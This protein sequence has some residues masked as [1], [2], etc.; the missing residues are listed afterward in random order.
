MKK[1]HLRMFRQLLAGA[2]VLTI[3][4]PVRAQVSNPSTWSDFVHGSGNPSVC[5]TFRMQ[6][7]NRRAN[8]NWSYTLS[9]GA[10]IPEG[11]KTLIVPVGGGI[12]LS[13]IPTDGYQ[14]VK[15]SFEFGAG[16]VVVGED[17]VVNYLYD[18]TVKAKSV[19]SPQTAD[20]S[21]DKTISF[22]QKFFM[23]DDSPSSLEIKTKRSAKSKN[24]YYTIKDIF[25]FG[26]IP[27]YSLFTG[28][29]SWNDT[30]RWSHL[31]PLRDRNALI[32]GKV[33]IDSSIECQSVALGGGCL[34]VTENGHFVTDTLLLCG[35][36][37]SLTVQGELTINKNIL[38]Q[39]TFAQKGE[40]YFLSFPFDVYLEGIDSRFQLK[41]DTF[42]GSGDYIYVQTYNS[43]KRASSQQTTGNWQVLSLV[44]TGNPLV[45][46]RGKGYLV[47]LDAAASDNTLTFSTSEGD[48]PAGFGKDATIDISFSLS[49]APGHG[50]WYLCGNPLPAPLSFS[51]IASNTALDGNIYLYNGS[52]YKTYPVGS[53]YLLPPSAAFF[54][55]TSAD[56]QL[57]IYGG[58][59]P[60][61]AML[62]WSGSSLRSSPIEP[63]SLPTD[64][65]PLKNNKQKIRLAGNM[66]YLDNLLS[67][68][69][70]TIVDLTGRIICSYL[71]PSGSSV[72]TLS[73][74][75]GLYIINIDTDSYSSQHKCVLTQ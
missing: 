16:N 33:T 46:E 48:I 31:P 37:N 8:D 35:I 71:V 18:K 30:V 36:D 17:M 26:Q 70:V 41:D 72:L 43:D 4:V 45:F 11:K 27:R 7:F 5:D 32:S 29:G 22:P 61:N 6:S 25:A 74:R 1:K 65:S 56:T 40:W 2:M 58:P 54:V 47:A 12:S 38:F 66:L 13:A 24:G 3:L 39:Y 14:Q 57:E 44:G 9:G 69:K 23:L 60:D 28:S 52:E 19:Y 64:T 10:E 63:G 62:L 73:V 53:N 75:P 21:S 42:S 67:N 55:K 51:R 34:S 20:Y 68:G 50:G 15:M 59:S 49:A